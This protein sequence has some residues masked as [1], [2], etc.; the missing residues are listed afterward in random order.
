MLHADRGRE[1]VR[2]DGERGRG[3]GLDSPRPRLL[4]A[5]EIP[6]RQL[7][8]LGRGE[9]EAIVRCEGELRGR[10]VEGDVCTDEGLRLDR[11]TDRLQRGGVSDG[12]LRVGVAKA[13]GDEDEELRPV[14]RERHA[15]RASVD[16]RLGDLF[17]RSRVDESNHVLSADREGSP[18]G[19]VRNARV[20]GQPHERIPDPS[21]GARIE[22]ENLA[23]ARHNRE[24]LPVGTDGDRSEHAA[25]AVH[26][27]DRSGAASEG[28]EQ[29]AAGLRRV[30]D[31][32]RLACE[33]ERQVE[34]FLDERLSPEALDELGRLRVSRFTA[35]DDREDPAGDGRRQHD[36]HPGEQHA[37][38]AV[39]ATDAFGLLL[40]CLAALGDELALELVELE[41]V[42]SAPVD[43][44]GEAGAPVELALI[45]P[46]RIPL[47]RRLSDV[48]A[49]PPSFGVLLDPPTQ[50]GPLT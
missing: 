12:D 42:A 48:T 5:P 31:R 39:G 2:A 24:R 9:D 19:A 26:D 28:G 22:E 43:S 34:V 35:L 27:P 47:G 45:P 44:G 13:Q 10:V 17:V 25:G 8:V 20:A 36:R 1:T 50:A 6:L 38:A 7:A 18:V 33:E 46:C 29:V 30:F 21:V 14:L 49:K 23:V 15:R 41:R 37:Q 32:D 40:G 3:A 4:T 11:L 16:D